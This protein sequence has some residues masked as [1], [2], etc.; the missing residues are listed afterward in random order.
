MFGFGAN[1]NVQHI[2]EKKK[3]KIFDSSPAKVVDWQISFP[4]G[5]MPLVEPAFASAFQKEGDE[6]HGLAFQITAEDKA[7]CNKMEPYETFIVPLQLYDGRTVDGQIYSH[8]NRKEEHVPSARYLGLIVD[9]AREAKLKPE[10]IEKV[11]SHPVNTA[12]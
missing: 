7:R 5:G 12:S 8:K 2:Q 3:L 6:I 10:Y 11:A 4:K 9:G 1:L